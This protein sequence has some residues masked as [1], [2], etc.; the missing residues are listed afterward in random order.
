MNDYDIDELRDRL[1]DYYGTAAVVLT[2]GEPF[3]FIPPVA[4]LFNVDEL[5][6]DEVFAEAVRMGII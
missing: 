5:N 3:G 6:D 4:E 1:R 2:E